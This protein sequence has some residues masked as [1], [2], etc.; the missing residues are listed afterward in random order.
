[1]DGEAEMTILFDIMIGH[2]TKKKNKEELKIMQKNGYHGKKF[3]L[4]CI[5]LPYSTVHCRLLQ[6]VLENISNWNNP[7]GNNFTLY[8]E[9]HY[10]FSWSYTPIFEITCFLQYLGVSFYFAQTA[11]ESKWYN[12]PP[13]KSKCLLLLMQSGYKP[14]PITAG[15]FFVLNFM[16]FGSIIKTSM[17]YLSFLITMKESNK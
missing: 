14:I 6:W 12:L 7:I 13:H 9:A 8:V 16:L 2:W 1:M 15:K 4:I 17:G 11:Y 5:I 3:S 10:P